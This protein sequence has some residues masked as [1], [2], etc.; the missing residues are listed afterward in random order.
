MALIPPALSIGHLIDLV[1][2]SQDDPQKVLEKSF[3]WEHSRAVELAKWLLTLS[4]SIFVALAAILFS[5]QLQS[6]VWIRNV[7]GYDFSALY[8]V[9]VIATLVGIF[10]VAALISSYLLQ[11]RYIETSALL[12]RILEVK[13]FMVRL[14]RDGLI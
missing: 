4:S 12:A 13:T 9:A 7:F 11:R 8:I 6:D 1:A 5:K 10:G 14:R 3:E 2:S